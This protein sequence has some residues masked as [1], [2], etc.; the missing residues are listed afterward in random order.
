MPP[1]TPTPLITVDPSKKAWEQ[2]KPLHNRWVCATHQ[3]N[4]ETHPGWAYLF[5]TSGQTENGQAGAA[6]LGV[7]GCR[8]VTLLS[9][10][11]ANTTNT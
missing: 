1:R 9:C 8:T 11:T 3:Q 10:S 7:T 6:Q 4:T 5:D 2:E